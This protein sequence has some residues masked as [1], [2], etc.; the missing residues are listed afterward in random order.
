V[1]N[2][3]TF[4]VISLIFVCRNVH[5]QLLAIAC[6]ADKLAFHDNV[7][8]R[9]GSAATARANLDHRYSTLLQLRSLYAPFLTKCNS[10]L[11]Q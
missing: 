8:I 1:V 5:A 11:Y 9:T 4:D 10:G 2:N 7:T 3:V 6:L